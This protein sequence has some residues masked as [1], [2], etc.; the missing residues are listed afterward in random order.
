MSFSELLSIILSKSWVLYS[1]RV[2]D[3]TTMGE[4]ADGCATIQPL[5]SHHKGYAR[6]AI[7]LIPKWVHEMKLVLKPTNEESGTTLSGRAKP[8]PRDFT[9]EK[10]LEKDILLNFRLR[11]VP[12]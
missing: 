8:L 9:L 5:A 4:I 6:S 12:Y 3:H 10:I 11:A 1:A 2:D 7:I